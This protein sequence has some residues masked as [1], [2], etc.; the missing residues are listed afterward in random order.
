MLIVQQN[1]GKEY[2]CTIFA[3]KAALGLS[4]SGV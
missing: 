4:A 3:L 2:K 1:W